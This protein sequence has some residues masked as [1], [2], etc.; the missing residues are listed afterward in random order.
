MIIGIG[1]P[2]SQS[3]IPLPM[4]CS[5]YCSRS[6]NAV[7]P[8]A[9]PQRAAFDRCE[10]CRECSKQHGGSKPEGQL[11]RASSRVVGSSFC[12]GN[13]V[14]DAFLRFGLTEAGASSHD[15]RNIRFIGGA[16]IIRFVKLGRPKARYFCLRLIGICI[17]RRR[18][19]RRPPQPRLRP[20]QQ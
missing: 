13:H 11:C 2:S 3:R 14:I 8:C 17:A 12:F 4:M 6:E 7:I 15:L 5:L 16:E 18:P 20:L 1:T 10:A 19:K 9:V